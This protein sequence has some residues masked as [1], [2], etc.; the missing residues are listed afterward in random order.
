MICIEDAQYFAP[1]DI[2]KKSKL[3]TYLEDIALLQRGAGEC[4]ITLAT[5]PDISKEI[6]ANWGVLVSFQNHL[7][8]DI[9]GELLNL[10]VRK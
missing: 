2:M 8:K 3:T 10:D 5:H 7:E 4:L 9:I 1:Q 6:L